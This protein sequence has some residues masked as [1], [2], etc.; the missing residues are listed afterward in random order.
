MN[1]IILILQREY[2]TRVRKRS[3]WIMT[4]LGPVLITSLYAAM[5]FIATRDGENTEKQTYSVI[6][7]SGYFTKQDSFKTTSLYP[8]SGTYDQGIDEL[9]KGNSDGLLCIWDKDVTKLDSV[10]LFA[11]HTPSFSEKKSLEEHLKSVIEKKKFADKGITKALLDSLKTTVNISGAEVGKDGKIKNASSELSSTVGFVLSLLIYMFIF[12][13]GVQVMRGVLEEKTNRIVEVII[14]SV[15]PFQMMMGKILG[16]AMVGLTQFLIWAGLSIALIAVVTS[17]MGTDAAAMSQTMNTP[18]MA[19]MAGG[20]QQMQLEGSLIGAAMNLNWPVI[21]GMFIFY[22][23][24]GY[25]LYSSMFAAVAAAVDQETDT[26]Q[27][28]LPITIPL[29]FG[30][31]IASRVVFDN[32][33]GSLATWTS[34]IPFTS[35]VVMVTR[36]PFLANIPLWQPLLSMAL[37]ILTFILMVYIAGKIYRTGIL[38]Y[39][40][41]ASW[42]DLGKWIF[43]K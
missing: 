29:I 4:I 33:Y 24:G 41:K 17:L 40:K 10:N 18:G 36:S 1:K 39:G 7:Q 42:K 5:I 31:V 13:Y 21:I 8:F 3:F 34:I 30:F 20:G 27:F 14:S 9:K 35:P 23:L 15:K 38:M 19:G 43:F 6:D 32:P 16:I 26:Q 28:M 2:L 37:L 22:F 12:M 11:D 25:L